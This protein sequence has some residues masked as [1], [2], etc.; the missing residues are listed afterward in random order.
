MERHL[1]LS[2]VLRIRIEN[3]CAN[4]FIRLIQL[5]KLIKN[6]RVLSVDGII[7]LGTT[8]QGWL[9]TYSPISMFSSMARSPPP[10]SSVIDE[11]SAPIDY[12]PSFLLYVLTTVTQAYSIF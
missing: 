3:L 1:R 4:N 2:N 10:T 5:V 7:S 12:M 9:M 8:E 11:S 6:I